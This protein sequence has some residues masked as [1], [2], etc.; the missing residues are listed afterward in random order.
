QRAMVRTLPAPSR[1]VRQA[2]FLVLSALKMPAVLVEVG[3]ISHPREGRRLGKD[4]D[5]ERIAQALAGSVKQYAEVVLA[6]RLDAP[7]DAVPA[8]HREPASM[9]ARLAVPIKAE[10]PGAS[11]PGVA[12]PGVAGLPATR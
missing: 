7:K 12:A 2:P 10:A 3:F 8:V 9:P 5:Q 6:R 4:D 1:G 11:L